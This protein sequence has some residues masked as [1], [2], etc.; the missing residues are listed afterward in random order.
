[1][2]DVLHRYMPLL[3]LTGPE[4]REPTIEDLFCA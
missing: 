4:N 1:M 2:Q 3:R